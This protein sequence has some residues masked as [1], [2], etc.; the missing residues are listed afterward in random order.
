[1]PLHCRFCKN[2]EVVKAVRGGYACPV[3]QREYD[4]RVYRR[5]GDDFTGESSRCAL[6][7]SAIHAMRR[8]D[9]SPRDFRDWF[10]GFHEEIMQ[11]EHS[12][13]V[14]FSN[15]IKD[16]SDAQRKSFLE[17]S[18]R[19]FAGCGAALQEI[20]EWTNTEEPVSDV[21]DHSFEKYKQG[22]LDIAQ[23]LVIHDDAMNGGRD[24][25]EGH[26]NLPSPRRRPPDNRPPRHGHAWPE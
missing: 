8:G 22:L 3:C 16:L 19:G 6:L 9:L 4:D 10:T 18:G 5:K 23:A 14:A 17:Y 15:M 21:L 2:V 25:E 20:L 24:D 1:M 7:A 12:L 26:G 11:A 13:R